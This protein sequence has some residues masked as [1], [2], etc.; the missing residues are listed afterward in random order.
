MKHRIRTLAVHSQ[1]FTVYEK[2]PISGQQPL[3]NTES[4]CTDLEPLA[5]NH[6]KKSNAF[7]WLKKAPLD[8]TLGEKPIAI[9][10]QA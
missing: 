10:V 3:K 7:D 5:P 2:E 1:S 8:S 9:Q 4:Q 6:H